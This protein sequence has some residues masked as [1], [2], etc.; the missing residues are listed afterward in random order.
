MDTENEAGWERFIAEGT[1]TDAGDDL[2]GRI[3]RFAYPAHPMALGWIK[4]V[5]TSSV[6]GRNRLAWHDGE[7]NDA[8]SD[9]MPVS[10]CRCYTISGLIG[11]VRAD[12]NDYVAGMTRIM[13]TVES[14]FGSIRVP[15]LRSIYAKSVTRVIIGCAP[16]H[17]DDFHVAWGRMILNVMAHGSDGDMGDT[18]LGIIPGPDLL[19]AI[20]EPSVRFAME[21]MLC[22]PVPVSPVTA[23]LTMSED[24]SVEER[25]RRIREL[26]TGLQTAI[27]STWSGDHG[28]HVCERRSRRYDLM[29]FGFRSLDTLAGLDAWRAALLIRVPSFVGLKDMPIELEWPTC[30]PSMTGRMD[31]YIASTDWTAPPSPGRMLGTL[32]DMLTDP[33]HPCVFDNSGTLRKAMDSRTGIT[34]GTHHHP[35][36]APADMLLRE[37]EEDPDIMRSFMILNDLMGPVLAER[38]R[39]VVPL[40]ALIDASDDLDRLLPKGFV[41]QC[42]AARMLRGIPP[43]H[44]ACAPRVEGDGGMPPFIIDIDS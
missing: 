15:G 40:S 1:G 6:S 16:H 38:H 19:D 17:G 27:A 28:I 12:E 7:F 41:K 23:L 32:S 25:V 37:S 35:P 36:G 9:I 43:G 33:F 8:I 22:I 34:H 4:D 11:L 44:R 3:L 30:P 39:P 5:D 31:A 42:F 14:S 20:M 18:P 21:D 26:E 2:L 29:P 13:D 24:G 10:V